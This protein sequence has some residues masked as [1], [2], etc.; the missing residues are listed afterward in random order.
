MASNRLYPITLSTFDA[1]ELTNAYQVINVGGF[2]DPCSI[3]KFVNTSHVS[4]MISYDGVH[5]HDVILYNSE[6]DIIGQ[7]NAT[8]PGM[9]AQW[10]KGTS[11]YVKYILGAAKSGDLYLIGYYHQ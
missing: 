6:V 1:T 9:R 4:V 3:I 8:L 2:S 11:V 10:K 5:D 7:T